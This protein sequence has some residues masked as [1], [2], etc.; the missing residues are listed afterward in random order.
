[1]ETLF[2][3][4]LL[5]THGGLSKVTRVHVFVTDSR[6]WEEA[7]SYCRRYYKD[8]STVSSSEEN[9]RLQSMLGTRNYL[10]WIG[11]HRNRSNLSQ[12]IWSDGDLE[13][14]YTCWTSDETDTSSDCVSVDGTGWDV[15]GCGNSL[16]FFCYLNTLVMEKKT[17][18]DALEYCRD[19]YTDLA[20]LTTEQQLRAV[21]S[22]LAGQMSIWIGLRFVAGQWYWMKSAGLGVQLPSCPALL[23]RCG[24]LNIATQMWENRD[25][26]EKLNFLCY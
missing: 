6:S 26:G 23:Y 12:F 24:A 25:C 10:G 14:N 3:F 18:D 20:T 13:T 17:W 19:H 4:F 22:N 15:F 2:L 21:K 1:M 9:N 8:L 5:I 16:S 11:M 7:Q